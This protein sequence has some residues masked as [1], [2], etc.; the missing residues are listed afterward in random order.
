MFT[1]LARIGDLWL[2]GV[3]LATIGQMKVVGARWD[4]AG[5]NKKYVIFVLC[6]SAKF[7]FVSCKIFKALFIYPLH[8]AGQ[9]SG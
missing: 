6:V 8:R 2:S 9:I 3:T 7:S 1:S 5:V 4:R